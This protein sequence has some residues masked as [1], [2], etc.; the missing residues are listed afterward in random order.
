MKGKQELNPLMGQRLAFTLARLYR[1]DRPPIYSVVF[2]LTLSV[3][4]W[5]PDPWSDLDAIVWRGAE[6]WVGKKEL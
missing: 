1:I 3:D 4:R 6:Q 5:R 2:P